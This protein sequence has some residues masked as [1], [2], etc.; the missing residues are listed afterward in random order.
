[1]NTSDLSQELGPIPDHVPQEL[2]FKLDSDDP[3]L[4]QNPFGLFQKV[5][6]E[7]PP[8][9]Y[10]LG[11]ALIT[12]PSDEG[13]WVI[14][15]AEA[16]REAL[17]KPEIFTTTVDYPGGTLV[18]P[19]RLIPLELD[20]PEHGKYRAL[21]APIFSPKAIDRMDDR[22][23]MVCEELMD[24]MIQKGETATFKEDFARPFPVLVFMAMMGLPLKDQKSFVKWEETVLG[25]QER[26]FEVIL[27]SAK[28]ISNYLSN[29]ITERQKNPQDDIITTL[30]QQQ[31]D[32][33]ALDHQTILDM[34]MLL[35]MAGLDTVTSGLMHVFYYLSTNPERKQQLI[36]DPDLIPDAIEELLRYHTWISSHRYV[37]QDIEFHGIKMKKGDRI[38]VGHMHV[39]HDKALFENPEE[40]DFHR[41]SNP[42][43]AFAMGVHRCAGSHL[44]RRELRYAV[45]EWLKRAPDFRLKPGTEEQ[46]SYTG[47][48]FH[49]RDIEIVWTPPS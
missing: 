39:S 5:R 17:Q 45:S 30:T 35:F 9:Y 15:T 22:I 37:A 44:A 19:Q 13:I 7:M 48:M 3:E 32:G 43:S 14:T 21:L 42:H 40:I 27:D 29:L 25:G 33:D 11:T 18:R 4:L 1:M 2:T 26:D 16:G 12:E 49:P 8:I 31:L 38:A 20:P 6:N 36:D 23:A 10:Q 34:C 46:V 47:I 41:D 24:N 28:S